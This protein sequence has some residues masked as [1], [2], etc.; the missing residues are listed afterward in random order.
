[1]SESTPYCP[2]MSAG[3]EIERLCTQ[4]SCAWYLKAYKMCSVYVIAHNAALDVQSKQ[5]K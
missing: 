1:M 2:L 4:E 3:Q 5:K